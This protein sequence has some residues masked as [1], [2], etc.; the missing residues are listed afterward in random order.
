[1]N[2][3]P[4]TDFVINFEDRQELKLVEDLVLDLQ[5]ILPGMLDAVM[6]IHEQMTHLHN[7]CVDL[8]R[9]GLCEMFA[10][11]NEFSEYI[12]EVKMYISRAK[13]LK[14][15]SKSTARLVSFLKKKDSGCES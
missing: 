5:V 6:G 4:L 13:S 3:A 7:T 12:R 14:D 11:I 9:E 2:L 15:M 1:M 8:P 10:I